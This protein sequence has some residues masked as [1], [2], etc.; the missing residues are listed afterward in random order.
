MPTLKAAIAIRD[1]FSATLNKFDRMITTDAQ[2]M[3][4]LDAA[5]KEVTASQQKMK[6]AMNQTIAGSNSLTGSIRGL[7]GAYAGLQGVKMLGSLSDE[8]SSINARLGMVSESAADAAANQKAIYEAAERSRGSYR[9]MASQVSKLALTA[10]KSFNGMDEVVSFAEQLNK[11]LVIGGASAQEQAS[12]AYQLTQAMQSGRLQGDEYKSIIEN[13]PLLAKSI[14]DYMRNVKGVTGSMKDWASQSLLTADVI[15]NAMAASAEETNR[16]FEQMPMTWGQVVTGIKNKIEKA[17]YP[18]LR[19]ISMIAQN[20]SKI[21]PLVRGAAFA[22]GIYVAVLGTVKM[23][24]LIA[25][26]ATTIY[27]FAL[28]ILGKTIGE[29]DLAQSKLNKTLLASPYFWIA[30]GI[31]LVVYASYK[32]LDAQRK[33]EQALYDIAEAHGIAQDNMLGGMYVAQTVTGKAVG[34]L[35]LVGQGFISLGKTIF[36]V[37]E[38]A[39]ETI[40]VFLDNLTIGF[41]NTIENSKYVWYEFLGSIS[42]GIAKASDAIGSLTGNKFKSI[43]FSVAADGFKD[44]AKEH[45]PKFKNKRSY[46]E[47]WNTAGSKVLDAWS[48]QTFLDAYNKGARKGD[49]FSSSLKS[50]FFG[51]SLGTDWGGKISDIAQNTKDTAKSVG[52]SKN[53]LEWL[54]KLAAQ[55]AINKFTTAEIKVDM[56]GVVQ[57]ISKEADVDGVVRALERKLTEAMYASAEGVHI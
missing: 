26:G 23:A 48:N 14:D 45:L 10:S 5:I 29:A 55:Q 44:K 20:W 38:G 32:L 50:S 22:V 24:H 42:S 27:T 41:Q 57:N 2:K 3:T 8:Y 43:Q 54:R 36:W 15:K 49:N 51:A 40:A 53:E 12:A 46:S 11:Q 16:R 30:A 56:G 7:V 9:D 1:E 47:A 35:Y 18:I 28:K 34:G 39:G 25:T 33:N 17:G 13:A 4:G 31:G 19:I 6:S 52:A 21:E 37:L